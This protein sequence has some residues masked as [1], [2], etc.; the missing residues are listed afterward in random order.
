MSS[1]QLRI[2]S[3]RLIT[4]FRARNVAQMKARGQHLPLLAEPGSKPLR[5]H[6]VEAHKLLFATRLSEVAV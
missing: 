6:F 3:N 5:L 1:G 2:Q 4:N